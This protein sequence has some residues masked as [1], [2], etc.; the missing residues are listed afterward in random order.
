MCST[1]L[2]CCRSRPSTS[3]NEKVF[4]DAGAIGHFEVPGEVG[5][6]LTTPDHTIVKDHEFGDGNLE[7]ERVQTLLFGNQQ[8]R[9]LASLVDI[10][11]GADPLRLRR[12]AP[13]SS[14]LQPTHPRR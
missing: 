12:P 3:V 2:I 7:I 14:S 13:R 8:A 10:E 6:A 9:P 4:A 1:P 11:V 5:A